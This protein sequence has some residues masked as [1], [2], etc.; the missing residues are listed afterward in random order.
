M[1]HIPSQ[2]VFGCVGEI[3][4]YAGVGGSFTHHNILST[5]ALADSGWIF[6]QWRTGGEVR[7]EGSS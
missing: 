2:K 6:S 1:I 3:S 7:H 4:N 5:T